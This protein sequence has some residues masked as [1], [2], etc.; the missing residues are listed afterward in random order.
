M[1]VP[2]T[3]FAS[4]AM[5]ASGDWRLTGSM[6]ATHSAHTFTLLTNGKTVAAGGVGTLTFI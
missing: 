5:A 6:S 2:V 3:L 1:A 4:A